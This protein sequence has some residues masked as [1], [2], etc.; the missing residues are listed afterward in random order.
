MDR[1]LLITGG[2]R[3]IGAATA[4]LAARRGHA[5]AINYRAARDAAEALAG[6][7]GRQG[8]KAIAVQA[9]VAREA[10]VVRMF[11]E[12]DARLGRLS[13]L[14]NNAGV[15]GGPPRP[16]AEL[17][18]S[19]LERLMAVNVIGLMLCCREAVRRMS[20]ARGG[21]G[22]AIVNVSSMAAVIGGRG[23]R[24]AYAGSKGA[25]DSFSVGLAKEV[26]QDGIR[27]NVLRP[28]MTR[29][30]MT[31]EVHED[32]E[33]LAQIA[34]TIAMGRIAEP[35]EMA[36]AILWLLSADASFI[37]GARLDAS[38]GGFVLAPARGG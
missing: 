23:G 11:G 1:V 12:V 8:G 3:G 28:G 6:E 15:N 14:V 17:E 29:S 21:S 18:A 33:R 20:T 31:A 24:S 34:A 35:E 38:G 16:V 36:S 2:A 9:D 19:E 22:G 32:P 13:A 7:I 27:V 30:D 26:A 10:D 4:R 5:V 25:V 37:S